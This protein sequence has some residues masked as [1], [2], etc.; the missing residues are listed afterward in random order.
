MPRKTE[1]VLAA[2]AAPEDAPEFRF[3]VIADNYAGGKQGSV[4]T[5]PS[6]YLTAALVAGGTLEP[7]SKSAAEA[8]EEAQE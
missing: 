6:D 4:V 1:P 5:L 2:P 7:L 3:R 8:V